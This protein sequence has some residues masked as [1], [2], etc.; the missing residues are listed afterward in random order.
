[1]RAWGLC[2]FYEESLWPLWLTTLC[3]GKAPWWATSSFARPKNG[4]RNALRDSRSDSRTTF[5]TGFPDLSP[6][7][8]RGSTPLESPENRR[9]AAV[10]KPVRTGVLPGTRQNFICAGCKE[11][12]HGSFRMRENIGKGDFS[13]E[14]TT[15]ACLFGNTPLL[16]ERIP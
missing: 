14:E 4:G 6:T 12:F 8:Q 7:T 5:S 13:Q 11:P 2:V 3:H 1:M 15:P 16:A 9:F 10:F